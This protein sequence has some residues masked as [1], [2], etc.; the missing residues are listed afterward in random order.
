M[1]DDLKLLYREIELLR[2]LDHPN[3]VKFYEVYQDQLYFHLVMEYCS[4]GELMQK[5]IKKKHFGE[6]EASEIMSKAF[7]AVKYLHEKGIVHRDIKPENFLYAS[8]E[9]DAEIKLID[10]GL[11]RYAEPNQTLS[12]QVGTPY[13]IAPEIVHGKYDCRCDNWSLGV[14][15]Y[16]LLCGHPPFNAENT[17][18]LAKKIICEEPDFH[19]GI[20]EN[21]SD[22]AKDLVVKLLIKDPRKR[23]TAKKALEHPWI[24]RSKKVQQIQHEKAEHVIESFKHFTIKKRLQKEVLNVLTTKISDAEL[25]EMRET[26]KYFDKENTGEITIADLK[27]VIKEQKLSVRPEELEEIMKHVHVEDD[28]QTI[29]FSEFL[30]LA[31]DTKV[32]LTREMLLWVFGHFDIDGTGFITAKNLKEAMTRAAKHMS[33][34]EITQMINETQCAKD[35]KISFEDFCELMKVSDYQ[36]D[37][38]EHHARVKYNSLD[39]PITKFRPNPLFFAKEA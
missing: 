19:T 18:N 25:K 27:K 21:I 9:A 26:F 33:E 32:Y 38:S 7:S 22:S 35:G 34:Q 13:Y 3:V 39:S 36:Q 6:A 23:M 24:K 15:M 2:D 17:V 14:M 20:W 5:F 29:S 30:F 4:G 16:I 37:A 12:S 10:F 11:S 1:K 28:S 8:K 31:M